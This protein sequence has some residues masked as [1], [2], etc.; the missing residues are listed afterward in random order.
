MSREARMPS[1]AG[2]SPEGRRSTYARNEPGPKLAPRSEHYAA[3]PGME[4][5]DE[6]FLHKGRQGARSTSV[7][8][9]MKDEYESARLEHSRF[10]GLVHH[11]A[12]TRPPG[13]E[14]KQPAT[15][16]F[17]L[18]ARDRKRVRRQQRAERDERD[19]VRPHTDDDDWRSS[20]ELCHSDGA[21]TQARE[22]PTM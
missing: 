6:A 8:E 12:P 16:P 2:S 1:S 19:G 18:T 20:G 7:A 5:W 4:W 3:I 22:P 15:M 13:G 10:H 9:R 17:Y 21:L 14:A 11:P